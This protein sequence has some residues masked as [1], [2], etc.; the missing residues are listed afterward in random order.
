MTQPKGPLVRKALTALAEAGYLLWG[1]GE[2]VEA[3][4]VTD[5]HDRLLHQLGAGEYADPITG[6]LP[7]DRDDV[8]E[9]PGRRNA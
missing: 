8:D 9:E 3:Q 5:I 1:A 4:K 7:R 2:T 6:R